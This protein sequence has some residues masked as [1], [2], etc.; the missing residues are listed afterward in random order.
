LEEAA[1]AVFGKP[2]AR[3][4]DGEGEQCFFFCAAV[5]IALAG[6][7]EHNFTLLCKF[8][9]VAEQVGDDLAQAR[10]ITDDGGRNLAVEDVGNVDAFF[11]S[12]A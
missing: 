4:A 7:R 9:G 2:N 8:D 3:I 6:N 11:D 5:L 1:H 12:A 10:H